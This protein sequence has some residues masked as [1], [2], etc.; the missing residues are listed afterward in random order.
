MQGTEK[1]VVD[2]PG[3]GAKVEEGFTEVVESGV[4]GEE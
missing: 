4:A 1:N 3:E 2:I